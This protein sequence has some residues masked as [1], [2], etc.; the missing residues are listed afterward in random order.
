[1]YGVYILNLYSN[2][3]ILYYQQTRGK[4]FFELIYY[5]YSIILTFYNAYN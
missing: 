4:Q 3:N 1:M 5:L 2:I